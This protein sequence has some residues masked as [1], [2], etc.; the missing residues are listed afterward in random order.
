VLGCAA[1]VWLPGQPVSGGHNPSPLQPLQGAAERKAPDAQAAL[2]VAPLTPQPGALE[3]IS[4]A[5]DAGPS[6][7]AEEVQ[8][9]IGSARKVV[10]SSP[11]RALELTARCLELSPHQPEC[12]ELTASAQARL[13]ELDE[14]H[15]QA[16]RAA[17]IEEPPGVDMREFEVI[18]AQAKK[19]VQ[20]RRYG[21]ALQLSEMCLR[22]IPDYLDCLLYSGSAL[23]ATGH[24]GMAA[25]RYRRFLEVAPPNHPKYKPVRMLVNDYGRH[26]PSRSGS[27]R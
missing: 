12:Q 11:T 20:A 15:K 22:R 16:E 27:A 3:P 13:R 26:S 10:R 24:P 4:Q 6:A 21:Q 8:W 14:A 7:P 17:E 2:A 25:E 18:V 9:L 1:L 19:A 23:A 5:G